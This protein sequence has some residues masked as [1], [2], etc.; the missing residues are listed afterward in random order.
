MKAN[1]SYHNIV[2]LNHCLTGAKR[3]GVEFSKFNGADRALCA[4]IDRYP[5]RYTADD[6]GNITHIDGAMV[7]NLPGYAFNTYAL[8]LKNK[9]EN[10]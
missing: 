10:K 4:W 6:C 2:V 9:K 7:I 3:L 8:A 5:N 1:K